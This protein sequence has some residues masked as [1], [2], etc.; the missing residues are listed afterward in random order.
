MKGQLLVVMV[1]ISDLRLKPEAVQ[2]FMKDEYFYLHI[3]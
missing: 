2:V 3:T 1:C